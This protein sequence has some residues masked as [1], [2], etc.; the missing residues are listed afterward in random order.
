MKG[1]T[2]GSLTWLLAKEIY[3]FALPSN[4]TKKHISPISMLDSHSMMQVGG[5]R[6]PNYYYWVNMSHAHSRTSFL[7]FV[8]GLLVKIMICQPYRIAMP[9]VFVQFCA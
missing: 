3:H 9:H 6:F 1:L 8:E 7:I 4:Q 2:S 5:Q